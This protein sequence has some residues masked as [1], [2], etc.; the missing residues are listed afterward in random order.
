MLEFKIMIFPIVIIGLISSI[1]TEFLKLFPWLGATDERKR[2]T[3]FIVA[4]IISLGY[5]ITRPEAF[6][7]G[8]IPLLAGSVA[9]SFLVYKSIIQ[10]VEELG[11]GLGRAIKKTTVSD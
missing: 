5:A 6:T 9:A 10:S 2:V 1:A 7:E 8:I 11:I 4:L 3:A